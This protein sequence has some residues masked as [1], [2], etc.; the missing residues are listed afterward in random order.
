MNSDTSLKSVNTIAYDK[1]LREKLDELHVSLGEG[2]TDIA[3]SA[4]QFTAKYKETAI[5]QLK[6]MSKLTADL[7]VALI[8]AR[9]GKQLDIEEQSQFDDM[10]KLADSLG[11]LQFQ[12]NRLIMDVTK[13]EKLSEQ[14]SSEGDSLLNAVMDVQSKLTVIRSDIN[15]LGIFSNNPQMATLFDNQHE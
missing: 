12:I 13:M 8:H 14:I 15:D 3:A 11:N 7:S 1:P 4:T 6:F 2:I 9:D 10:K 5:I